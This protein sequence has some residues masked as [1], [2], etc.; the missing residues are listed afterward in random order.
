[1]EMLEMTITPLYSNELEER[2]LLCWL[3]V[4]DY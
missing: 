3:K 1:M 2:R 4:Q